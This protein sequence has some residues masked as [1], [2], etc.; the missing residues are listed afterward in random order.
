MIETC[1]ACGQKNKRPLAKLAS[2]GKCG[3]CGAVLP[4]LATPMAVDAK[5]FDEIVRTAKVPVL[6][7]F[8]AEWCMPCRMAAPAVARAAEELAG[9]A[10]VLKVNTEEHPDLAQKFDVRGIPNFLILQGGKVAR[11]QAGLVDHKQ[12][13]SWVK[14]AARA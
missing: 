8:W 12:L 6:V 3:K 4:P 9:E 13:K 11:Q 5:A 10:I 7:D 2:R 14:E 1:A